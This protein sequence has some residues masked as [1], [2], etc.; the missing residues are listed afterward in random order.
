[1]S[2]TSAAYVANNETIVCYAPQ[3]VTSKG[4]WLGDKPLKFSLPVFIL[5]LLLIVATSRLLHFFLKPFRQPRVVSEVLGGFILGPSVLGRS[6]FGEIVFPLRSVMVL[7][8]MANVGL[9]YFLFL[10]GVE[11][12]ISIIL[13]IG[14][15]ALAIALAGML[16]PFIISVSSSF[17][18]HKE[19]TTI[20][21]SSY[22]LFLAVALSVTAFPVLVR[23]L[24]ELKLLKMEIGR[25]AMSAALI[26]DLCGW[27]ILAFAIAL[28]DKETF[29]WTSIWVLLSST[30]FVIFCIFMVQPAVKWLIRQ[31]PE[32]DTFN[33][34]SICVILSGVMIS[35]FITEAIGIHAVFGAIIYGLV[36]PNGPLG[37]T[38][39]EKLEDFVTGILLPLF[40]AS[41][42]LKTKISIVVGVYNWALLIL[43][44]FLACAGKV[45]G[46]LLVALFY[47]MP[48]REAVTLGFLMNTKGLIEMI[49]LNLAKKQ[50]V[51]DERLFT[52]MVIAAVAMTGMITPIVTIIYRPARTSVPYKWRA[53][54]ST[55]PDA[56]LRVLVCIHSPR[57]VPTIINLLEASHPTKNSPLCIYVLHLVEL[58]GR[59]SAMLI[60]QGTQESG[61]PAVRPMQAQSKH[62]I[63][64]F[65]NFMQHNS[66]VS[67]HPLTAIS[68]YSTMHQDICN[69][70]EDKRVTFI[71]IP[72]HKQQM[73][74]GE[75]ASMNPAFRILNQNV[76]ANAPC[77]VGILVDRGLSGSTDLA[78]NQLSHHIA[79]L[80]F[81]GPDDRE[82]LS[83]ASRMAEH[84][85]NSL[86]VVRFLPGENSA[87]LKTEPSL[88]P[89]NPKTLKEQT[90]SRHEK[91]LDNDLI[92]DFRIKAK[93]DES[94]VYIE[95]LVNN[96]EE[97]VEAL[98]SVDDIHDLFIVGRG[99]GI[100]SHL[101]AGLTDWSECPELG[102]IGDLLA[103]S[104]FSAKVSVLVVQ[105]YTASGVQEEETGVSDSPSQ[106]D[107]Q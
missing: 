2:N 106:Q 70:A 44:I 62:V 63:K 107:K 19:L 14:R 92:K 77:S 57:N 84:P 56:E 40:F 69:M 36:I 31:T 28:S 104:D 35:G 86:C 89:T 3:M 25:L 85:G 67:V 47:K 100:F 38:L 83:Y 45:V 23:I 105:Q 73:V 80:F 95:R 24:A 29:E 50:N 6:K 26:S 15:K 58:T 81:G 87:K 39:I 54:Q 91:L 9:L 21:R 30:L 97:T 94:L 78:V 82:A 46:T 20:E 5:Q 98:R 12:D 1:M 101:T 68:H 102:A 51:L 76:L 74:D 88:A 43:V 27:F 64:S 7:D 66:C 49:V 17:I 71:V 42:G 8:T 37:I 59:A 34:F 53:I 41:T 90:D 48:L 99:Q 11:M 10:I 4:I 65:K 79:V 93:N 52:I 72:F 55:K 75:M 22:I 32:G 60:V 61:R 96:G 16:F 13:H 33:E 18:I 103:S